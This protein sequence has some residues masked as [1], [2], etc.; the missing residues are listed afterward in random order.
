MKMIKCSKCNGG[1][2]KPV[3]LECC[4]FCCNVLQLKEGDKDEE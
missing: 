4:P 3:K 1:F 2:T